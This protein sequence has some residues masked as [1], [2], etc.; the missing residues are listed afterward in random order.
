MAAVH[1]FTFKI[2]ADPLNEHRFR[3]T[4]CEGDQVHIRSPH[5]YATR[6]EA[7][8]EAQKAVIKRSS[9]RIGLGNT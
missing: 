9:L 5:S 3:W 7:E 1:S 2:E 4:V 6:R 8:A